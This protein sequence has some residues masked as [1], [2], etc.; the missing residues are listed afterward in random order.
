MDKFLKNMYGI[1]FSP[2]ETIEN[3]IEAQPLLQ[4]VMIVILLSI[5]AYLL[6]YDVAIITGFDIVLMLMGVLGIVISSIII[7][8]ILASFFELVSRVFN[9]ESH[10]KQLLVLIG[11]ALLPWIFMAPLELLKIN[12]ILAAI[13]SLFEVGVWLWSICLIFLSVKS[14]YKLTTKKTWLFLLTPFLGTIVA[15]NW[16]SQFFTI[17]M[18]IF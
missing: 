12:S 16:V 3:L 15:L 4:A 18:N 14:L 2:E 5:A 13:S 17:V 11:F 7:W 9:D 10:Y 8:L 6:T 1:L